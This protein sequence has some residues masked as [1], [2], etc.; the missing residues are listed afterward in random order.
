MPRRRNKM[1]Y[2]GDRYLDYIQGLAIEEHI[3]KGLLTHTLGCL[4]ETR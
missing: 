2:P 3:S 1:Y 4:K